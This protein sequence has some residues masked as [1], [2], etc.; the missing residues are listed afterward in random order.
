[1]PLRIISA[2]E[3]LAESRGIKA[4]IFGGSGQGK[5]SLLWTLPADR[6][7]FMDLEAGDLAVEGWTGDTIRPRTWQECRDFAAFI[8]GPNPALRDDQPYSPAH[9]A[10]AC[11]QFGDPAKLDRYETLFV[12]SIS[13]AGRLCFQWCRGQAEAFSEKSGK[14]DIRGAYGLHG[15]EMI[16][17]AAHAWQE[18]HLC[19]DP[20]RKT[21]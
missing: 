7:I 8:G 3:R 16:A 1:M 20:R 13:V 18:H 10:A 4:A 9:Y 19:R 14:P 6:T 2:E 12:D 5:T 21:R 15:R 17:S 11:E